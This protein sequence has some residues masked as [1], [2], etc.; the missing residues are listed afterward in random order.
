MNQL[1]MMFE[2]ERTLALRDIL[3][4]NVGGIYSGQLMLH[5]KENGKIGLVDLGTATSSPL[6]FDTLDQATDYFKNIKV[7]RNIIDVVSRQDWVVYVP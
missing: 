5:V 7:D 6:E 1:R 3:S 2:D 4:W